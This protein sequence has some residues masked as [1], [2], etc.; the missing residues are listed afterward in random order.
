MTYNLGSKATG[1]TQINGRLLA[2]IANNRV[3]VNQH[4][5]FLLNVGRFPLSAPPPAGSTPLNPGREQGIA[6]MRDVITQ[7]PN[8]SPG[9]KCLL[10]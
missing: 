8:I 1:S 3:R 6:E 2:I 9:K 7:T 5:R 10:I 4:K